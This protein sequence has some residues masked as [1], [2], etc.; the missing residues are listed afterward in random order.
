[1][2]TA[3]ASRV[4]SNKMEVQAFRDQELS[5]DSIGASTQRDIAHKIDMRQQKH[6]Q[7]RNVVVTPSGPILP[8]LVARLRGQVCPDSTP[9]GARNPTRQSFTNAPH[10]TVLA[11]KVLVGLMA[12]LCFAWTV[13]LILLTVRPN[14]TVNWVMNTENFD[15]G[16]FWLLVDPPATM[17]WLSLCGFSLV[18]ISYASVLV[19][20]LKRQRHRHRI[21]RASQIES[22]TASLRQDIILGIW[23]RRRSKAGFNQR[24]DGQGSSARNQRTSKND[25]A[26]KSLLP[27]SARSIAT[28]SANEASVLGLHTYRNPAGVD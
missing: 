24:R 5:S 11:M 9:E 10:G 26:D 16:S 1:M 22:M 15:D 13:W 12:L 18:A 14:D 4:A 8:A 3:E 7:Q 6:L 23:P 17:T 25:S 20:I 21:T 2:T 27:Y 19:K 28:M